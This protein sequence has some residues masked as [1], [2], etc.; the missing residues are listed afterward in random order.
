MQNKSNSEGRASV[1]IVE[2][3]RH[4]P[5]PQNTAVSLGSRQ[6]GIGRLEASMLIPSKCQLL[7]AGEV[8]C[9]GNAALSAFAQRLLWLNAREIEQHPASKSASRP[10]VNP[11]TAGLSPPDV[12][13]KIEQSQKINDG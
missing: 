11:L 4:E 12:S 13:S 10:D 3:L 1:I 2:A 5:S 8:Y 9:S 6:C 7:N